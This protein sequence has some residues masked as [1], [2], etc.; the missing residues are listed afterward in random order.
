MDNREKF[1]NRVCA[2]IRAKS[3]HKDIRAE[4]SSHIDEIVEAEISSGLSPEAAEEKALKRMG[5]PEDIGLKLDKKHR[6]KTD[7]LLLAAAFAIAAAGVAVSLA[8]DIGQGKALYIVLGFGLMVGMMFVDCTRVRYHALPIYLAYSALLVILSVKDSYIDHVGIRAAVAALQLAQLAPVLFMPLIFRRE[9]FG[10]IRTAGLCV[11]MA[12]PFFAVITTNKAAY[13]LLLGLSYLII[14]SIL[15]V[16]KNKTALRLLPVSVCLTAAMIIGVF[17][18]FPYMTERLEVFF[19]A[20]LSDPNGNGWL[21]MQVSEVIGRARLIGGAPGDIPDVFSIFSEYALVG[22]LGR[23]GW[24]PTVAVMVAAALLIW[25][26]FAACSK[27]NDP[28]G[29]AMAISA[30]AVLALRY[31]INILINFN[32]FPVVGLGLPI[33]GG[34]GCDCFVMFMLLGVVMS[35][36]RRRDITA[37]MESVESAA[38]WHGVVDK[39]FEKR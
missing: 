15:A 8:A 38:F 14:L 4:L 2:C 24:L 29:F 30:G 3:V 33:I 37:R 19:S 11:L 18:M 34:G 32:L 9:S 23:Y 28:C 1:L 17:V 7:W 26:L 6:P 36:C 39:I 25:R 31:V 10:P 20:G 35:V 12:I 27:V 16:M 21:T 22:I 5:S 13:I